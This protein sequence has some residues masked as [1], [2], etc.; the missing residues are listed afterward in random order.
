MQ[1]GAKVD[2]IDPTMGAW[3]EAIIMKVSMDESEKVLYHVRLEEYVPFHV[4][5]CALDFYQITE[6]VNC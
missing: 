6:S 4:W 1:T 5:F 3:F 2:A